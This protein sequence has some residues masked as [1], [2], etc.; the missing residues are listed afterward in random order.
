M[1]EQVIANSAR[2]KGNE[3]VLGIGRLHMVVEPLSRLVLLHLPGSGKL[4]IVRCVVWSQSRVPGDIAK[5]IDNAPYRQ[6][7]RN[8]AV[9]A[10]RREVRLQPTHRKAAVDCDQDG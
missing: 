7:C 8:L 10:E 1:I 5:E 4:R 9:G 2:T 6:D 3:L